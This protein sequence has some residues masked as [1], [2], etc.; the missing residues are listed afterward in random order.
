MKSTSDGKLILCVIKLPKYHK[1]NPTNLLYYPST[2]IKKI[3]AWKPKP[4]TASQKN[5]FSINIVGH[6]LVHAPASYT[7]S[8]HP[9]TN[10]PPRGMK[11]FRLK[12]TTGLNRSPI[13]I[14]IYVCV[15]VYI[16]W[17]NG[18]AIYNQLTLGKVRK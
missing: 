5:Y 12:L 7:Y 2:I 15:C 4:T 3:G 6:H 9:F 1:L 14:Y 18:K 11:L 16:I 10:L 13:Y 17:S 8:W